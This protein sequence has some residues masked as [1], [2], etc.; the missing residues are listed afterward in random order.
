MLQTSEQIGAI[1]KAMAAVQAEV[2]NV[3]KDAAN[4]HFKS[5]YA[6]LAAVLEV[7][8]PALAKQG[9]AL[10]QGVGNGEDGRVYVTT[11]L[12]HE[13]GEW[14]ECSV[15]VPP[16]KNDAQGV[17]SAVS[18][19]RRYSLAA[20]CGVSQDDDDGNAAVQPR[21]STPAPQA[22]PEP[23][24]ASVPTSWTDG[25]RAAFCAELGRMG[26]KYEDVA[27]WCEHLGK[28]R[29]SQAGQSARDGLL[30]ALAGPR[31]KDFGDWYAAQGS[32][33]DPQEPI[34]KPIHDDQE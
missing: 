22:Q 3:A 31:R 24:P 6:T 7:V 10:W 13:S 28:A 20:M 27:K 9:I 18:Y 12:A 14:V 4:P 25:Q 11:R 2:Q 32:D 8:R 23:T 15:G 1:S 17:G 33:L 21:A 29:P 5:K 16:M 34:D 30:R 19:L 26:L